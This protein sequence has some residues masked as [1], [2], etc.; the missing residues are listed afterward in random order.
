VHGLSRE[1]VKIEA[2]ES[3][4]SGQQTG[5]FSLHLLR[6]NLR[7]LYKLF[8]KGS[9]VDMNKWGVHPNIVEGD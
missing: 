2:H 3:W 1:D 5:C 7:E 8:L 9:G 6:D 4:N